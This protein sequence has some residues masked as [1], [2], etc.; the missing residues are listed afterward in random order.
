MAEVREPMAKGYEF[1]VDSREKENRTKQIVLQKGIPHRIDALNADFVLRKI[2]GVM[3][4][5][6]GIERKAVADLVQSITSKRIFDQIPKLKNNHKICFLFISGSLEEHEQ[7]L[8][9]MKPPLHLHKNVIYGALASMM[10]RDRL[11]VCWFPNDSALVEM[12]YRVC[13]KVS[14]GK[15][16]EERSVEPKYDMYDPA[17]MLNNHI[18][19]VS[20]EKAKSLLAKFGTLKGVAI[21]DTAQLQSVAGIGPETASL[22][23]QLFRKGV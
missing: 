21:A 8:F 22:I 11:N 20:L 1:L 3:V 9:M 23:Y 19:G 18:P 17:R 13:K 15:W 5:I 10:V 2:D 6:V 7:K 4:D 12:A 14:E 16:G